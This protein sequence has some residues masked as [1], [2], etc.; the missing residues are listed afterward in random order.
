MK[1]TIHHIV[2]KEQINKALEHYIDELNKAKN[3]IIKRIAD[4]LN[5]YHQNH[6]RTFWQWINNFG[7]FPHY[8]KYSYDD[9]RAFYTLN[10]CQYKESINIESLK[11]VEC[12][13]LNFTHS[14]YSNKNVYR[15]NQIINRLLKMSRMLLYYPIDSKVEIDEEEFGL[16]WYD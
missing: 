15:Y 13:F 4:N 9:I 6:Y 16:I 10:C 11:L 1:T 5:E 8:Q 2:L 12:S 14:S 3:E 7:K